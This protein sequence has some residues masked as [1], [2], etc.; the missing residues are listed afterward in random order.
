M[1]H[2]P[3]MVRLGM[4]LLSG[5][6]LVTTGAGNARAQVAT[7]STAGEVF[8]VDVTSAAKRGWHIRNMEVE[9]QDSHGTTLHLTMAGAKQAR[10][11]SVSF[12]ADTRI[13]VYYTSDTVALPSHN[14]FYTDERALL[15]LLAGT[16]MITSDEAC[17]SLSLVRGKHSATFDPNGYF[18]ATPAT[19][20]AAAQRALATAMS[21][22][23]NKGYELVNVSKSSQRPPGAHSAIDIELV[24]GASVT[25]HVGL[26]AKSQIVFVQRRESP[27]GMEYQK[28][29]HKRT[30][31]RGLVAGRSVRSLRLV[32]GKGG[33][34]Q[35]VIASVAGGRALVIQMADFESVYHG[36]GC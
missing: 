1:S 26:D 7:V 15:K 29:K 4:C 19:T 5:L 16:G 2:Y 11:Y 22:A 17:G 25:L 27:T 6:V 31:A 12:D 10:R 32:T 23:L 34:V 24:N 21:R 14:R 30:L 9:Y 20:G 36:C 18:V 3:N 28:Y 8:A 13:A 33:T 35:R